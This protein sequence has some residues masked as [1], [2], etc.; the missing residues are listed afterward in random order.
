MAFSIE[1]RHPFLDF[2]LVE[3]SL[4]SAPEYIIGE[5]VRKRLLRSALSDLIDPKVLGRID[6][7]GFQTPNE[8]LRSEEFKNAFNMLLERAPQ[9]LSSFIHFGRARRLLDGR[10]SRRKASDAW[11]IY[12]LLLWYDQSVAGKET[13]NP[14]LL[15]LL[16]S[17]QVSANRNEPF[18]HPR[19]LESVGDSFDVGG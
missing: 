5:G 9:S 16:S 4:Q 17:N 13:I 12:S 3:L 10:W 14:D 1:T 8:W 19:P 11:R 2:R 18:F 6:K 7:I 15:A